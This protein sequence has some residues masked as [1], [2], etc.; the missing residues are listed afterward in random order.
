MQKRKS[1]TG[2]ARKSA[3]QVRY[4]T[5]KQ[6]LIPR[7]KTLAGI[8]RGCGVTLSMVSHVARGRRVSRHVE[9]A[10]ARAIGKKRKELWGNA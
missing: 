10:L 7:G 5:I 3:A 1:T 6:A 8:A 4:E 2:Q 9:N